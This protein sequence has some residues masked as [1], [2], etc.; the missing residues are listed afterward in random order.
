[1]RDSKVKRIIVGFL[2]L[3]CLS[4]FSGAA[5]AQSEHSGKDGMQTQQQGGQPPSPEMQQQ[6]MQQM[7]QVMGPMMGMMMGQMV[8]GMA[9][10][11]AKP[12][13]A[14]YFAAFMRNYYQALMKQGF[15]SEEAMQIVISSG[16]PSIGKGAR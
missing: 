13:V 1:M 16:L 6:Q 4:V 5:A 15:S 10:S 7:E 2:I 9:K 3:G 14:D 11:M 12:E 8:E